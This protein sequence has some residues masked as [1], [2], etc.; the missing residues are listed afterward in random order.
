MEKNVVFQMMANLLSK[1]KE[2]PESVTESDKSFLQKI[3]FDLCK[4]LNFSE[5]SA[6]A[7]KWTV[8]K[9]HS[10][11]E[12]LSGIAPYEVVNEGQNIILDLGA[13]EMLKLICGT[14]KTAFDNANAKIYVGTDT[15]SENASQTGVLAQGPNKAYAAMDSG[16]PQVSGRTATFR[17]S[18]GDSAA[19]FAWAESSVTNGDGVGSVAMNRKVST[20]GT[21]NGGTWT[22]Q[23]TITLVSA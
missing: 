1:M 4:S 7:V 12:K 23:M 20:M 22:L 13:T 14:G 18:F 8:E 10:M 19:N 6:W 15:T 3:Y 17:A 11:E 5:H 9:W 21:K 2:H 16:Y